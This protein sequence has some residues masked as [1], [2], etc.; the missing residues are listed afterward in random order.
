MALMVKEKRIRNLY[1]P[2]VPF[3][4]GCGTYIDKNVHTMLR[5]PWH[6]SKSWIRP[7]IYFIFI[8]SGLLKASLCHG[9][10]QYTVVQV[11]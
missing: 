1:L 2:E 3:F 10:V 4:P 8:Y 7:Q 9:T 11:L 6:R 5:M